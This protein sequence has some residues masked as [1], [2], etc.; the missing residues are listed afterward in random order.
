MLKPFLAIAVG[1]ALFAAG[2]AFAAQQKDTY[3]VTANLKA[4]FEV[5][6]PQGV[7]VG[8]TGFFTG[9]AVELANDRARLTWRLTFSKLTGRAIADHIHSGKVGKA[10]PVM[11]AL[12]GPCSNGQRGTATISHRQLRAIELGRTYVN[13]HTVKNAGGEIRGQAK[14]SE[15]AG[16]D[17]GGTSSQPT[18]TTTTTTPYP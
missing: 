17:D 6:K 2:L 7:K 9:R 5:P 15:T 11:V 10:G 13:V 16:G 12:C 1:A 18:E 4:R 3:K 14:A 8:A